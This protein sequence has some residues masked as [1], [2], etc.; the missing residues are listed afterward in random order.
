MVNA[1]DSTTGNSGAQ[2]R[3]CLLVAGEERTVT[4]WMPESGRIVLGRAPGCD[5]VVQ[6]TSV[7]GVHAALFIG[8]TLEIED[9]G[10]KN[11]TKVKDRVL[12][13]GQRAHVAL[14]EPLALGNALLV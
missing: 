2:G 13:A 5:V 8:P 10:S 14:G 1:N 11:G 3:L 4:F 6:D 12:V 7:S 9:L